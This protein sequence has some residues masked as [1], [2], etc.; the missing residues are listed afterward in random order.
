MNAK[1]MFEELGYQRNE[2]NEKIIYLIE[3]KG[4]FYYQ[5]IIFNLLQKVIVIDGNFLEVAIETNLLKAIDKQAN[6]LGWIEEEKQEIKQETNYEHYKDEI[7]EYYGQNLAVVKGRPTLCCETNCNNCD[8]K[9]NQ[10]GCRE[11]AKYWLKKPYKKLTYK[12]N[13][14]EIDLLQSFLKGHPLRYQF[15]NINA[16]AEM[17]EKGYFKGIDE[18]EAVEDILANC[19]VIG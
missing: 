15:K 7:I 19:E 12:L 14:F 18:N 10:I 1:E 8:F 5:E 16:L 4:S 2:E 9:I 17:K 6:E 13:K 3:T 11:T